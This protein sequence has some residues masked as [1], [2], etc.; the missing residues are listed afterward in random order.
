M[1][2]LKEE[3]TL[4]YS[5]L[6]DCGE[7]LSCKVPPSGGHNNT[8]V[9]STKYTYYR[10][11]ILLTLVH[12]SALSGIPPECSN[13][14]IL[15]AS[16]TRIDNKRPN[17]SALAVTGHKCLWPLGQRKSQLNSHNNYIK[18]QYIHKWI[19]YKPSVTCKSQTKSKYIECENYSKSQYT[20]N[21]TKFL[22]N[23]QRETIKVCY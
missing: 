1:K 10:F 7:L 5:S 4:L 17:Y 20:K 23:Y 2:S 16:T 13:C 21:T 14:F 18:S 8:G 3:V 6:E 15:T 19:Y 12:I 9:Y 22:Q 11:S